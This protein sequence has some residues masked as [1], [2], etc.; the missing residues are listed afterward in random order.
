MRRAKREQWAHWANGEGSR[1]GHDRHE[2]LTPEQ[3]EGAKA[4]K[5]S[6][7]LVALAQNE[8]IKLTE[9][10]LNAIS[11]GYYSIRE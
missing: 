7:E 3:L 11:G 6:D 10:Q 9:E 5:T 2:I 4:C 8:G 1:H